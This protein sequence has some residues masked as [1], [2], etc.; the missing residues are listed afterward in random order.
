LN[1]NRRYLRGANPALYAMES[2][3]FWS[4][5][6]DHDLPLTRMFQGSWKY[7]HRRE[8]PTVEGCLDVFAWL[9]RANKP[10][11]FEAAKNC[12]FFEILQDLLVRDGIRT[13]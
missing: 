10:G 2:M 11:T 6:G 3:I 9:I 4:S 7:A 5:K 1:D 12:L 8:R 13:R